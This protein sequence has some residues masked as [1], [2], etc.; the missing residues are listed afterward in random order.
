MLFPVDLTR[1]LISK[2]SHLLYLP[3]LSHFLEKKL[4]IHLL[5]KPPKIPR[6]VGTELLQQVGRIP[7]G[8]AELRAEHERLS[9]E[10]TL[11]A[12]IRH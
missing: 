12:F 6:Y 5:L 11:Q 4:I 7:G 8:R 2:T 10:N 9:A 3:R 1:R